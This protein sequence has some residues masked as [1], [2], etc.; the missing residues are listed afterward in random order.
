MCEALAKA[1]KVGVVNW[2]E[3]IRTLKRRMNPDEWG[4]VTYDSTF[5]RMQ[6]FWCLILDDVGSGAS[7]TDWAWRELEDLIDYRY[8]N[9]LIT[10][11][12]TNLNLKDFPDRIVS[13]FRDG[14]KSRLILNES[15]DFRPRKR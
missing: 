14:E 10:V 5:R 15:P 3:E 11:I 9:N 7:S 4:V 12:T 8:R 2:P 13:R 1:L 6:R